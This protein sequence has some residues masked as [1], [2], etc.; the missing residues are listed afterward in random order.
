[1]TGTG[2]ETQRV[3]DRRR[4]WDRV[5]ERAGTPLVHLDLDDG[6]ADDEAIASLHRGLWPALEAA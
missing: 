4:A 1:L 2:A 3:A 5:A 6:P